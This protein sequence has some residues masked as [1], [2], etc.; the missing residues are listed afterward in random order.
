MKKDKLKE[1][2]IEQLEKKEKNLK[3][4]IGFFIPLIVLLFFF[5]IRDVVNGEKVD[6]SILTI[7]ICTLGGPISLYP[8]LKQVQEEIR[9]RN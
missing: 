9:R 1:L 5:I 8:D 6:M 4:F 7:A 3:M 2:S